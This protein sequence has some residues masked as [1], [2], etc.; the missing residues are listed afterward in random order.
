MFTLYRVLHIYCIFDE[1]SSSKAIAFQRLFE[2]CDKNGQLKIINENLA[3]IEQLS[4]E[5]KMKLD[6]RRTL[7]RNCAHALDKNNES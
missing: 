7:Y 6:T 1:K 5:W 2:I 3:N 4:K